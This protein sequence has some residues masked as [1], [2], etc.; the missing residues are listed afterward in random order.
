MKK[1]FTLLELIIVVI[2]IGILVSIALPQMINVAERG[3]SSEGVANLGAFRDAQLRYYAQ[4][5]AYT[6]TVT[7]LDVTLTA[8]RYFTYVANGAATDTNTCATATRNTTDIGSFGAYTLCITP[9]GA[10]TCNGAVACPKL[11]YTSAAC[12]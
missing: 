11:G 12:P 3:R 2:V 10:I 8:V 4:W 7:N 5:S 1:G 6:G 9:N